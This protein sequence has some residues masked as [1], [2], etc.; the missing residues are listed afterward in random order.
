[1]N[2]FPVDNGAHVRIIP[3]RVPEIEFEAPVQN[4]DVLNEF[5]STVKALGLSHVFK[6]R[7]REGKIQ[8]RKFKAHWTLLG[9]RKTLRLYGTDF[10]SLS[11]RGELS[12]ETLLR[13]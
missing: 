9:E 12:V 4:S 2:L 8:Y 13:P 5:A 11:R 10:F 3:G 1:M 6:F 7:L